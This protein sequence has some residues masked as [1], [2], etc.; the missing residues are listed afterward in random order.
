[1]FAFEPGYESPLEICLVLLLAMQ[2]QPVVDGS[3]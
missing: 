2:P 1:M 3:F